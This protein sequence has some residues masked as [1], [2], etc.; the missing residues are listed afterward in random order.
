MAN[1]DVE[2]QTDIPGT[3]KCF[4]FL[5]LASYARTTRYE[6]AF[7]PKRKK[8]ARSLRSLGL[9]SLRTAASPELYS[10]SRG[11]EVAPRVP[12]QQPFSDRYQIIFYTNF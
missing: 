9:A 10:T 2:S 6:E 1:Y 4:D 11:L 12:T 8:R 3:E 5:F 7:L